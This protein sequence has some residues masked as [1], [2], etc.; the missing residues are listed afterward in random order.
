MIENNIHQIW[1]GGSRIPTH[2]KV[3][4]DRM[5][6][7]HQ[8]KF[9]Y[10]LWNDDNLPDIPDILMEI[11]NS[12]NEPAIKADLLRMYVVYKFGGFYLD[13]DFD[14]IDGFREDILPIDMFDGILVYN[15]S[16]QLSALANSVFGFKKEHPLLKFMLDNIV[17][18]QQWIGPNWWSQTVSKYFNT[19]IEKMTVEEFKNKLNQHNL[20]LGVWKDIEN[21]CFRHDPLSSWVHGSIWNEKL[22]NGDY[23]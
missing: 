19:D 8:G 3:Y 5:K 22:N 17:H 18:K 21:N 23:D 2:I 4:M 11:Y 20:E 13:A 15:G 16:Y 10:F 1:V 6:N 7:H 14:T 9:N 12:Y